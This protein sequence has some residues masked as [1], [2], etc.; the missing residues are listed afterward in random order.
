M[1]RNTFYGLFDNR[2]AAIRFALALG[3]SRLR[4]AIDDGAGGTGPWPRRMEAVIESLLDMVEDDPHLSEL[5]LLHGRCVMDT[6]GPFDPELVQA[7]AGVIRAGR[8]DGPDPGPGPRAE[9][10]VAYGVLAVIAE[11]LR[12]DEAESLRELAGEL[13]ELAIMPFREIDPLPAAR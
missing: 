2:D 3:N 6:A 8:Q 9:E 13:S 12:R 5:C 4:E 10:L 1:A 7:L 11:R